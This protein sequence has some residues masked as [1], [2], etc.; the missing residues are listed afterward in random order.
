MRVAVGMITLG[1]HFDAGRYHATKWATSA[2]EGQIDWPPSPW[3]ILRAIVSSWKTYHD[4]IPDDAMSPIIRAMCSEA[5]KFRLPPASQSHTRHYVPVI[6]HDGK[7]LTKTEKMIDAFLVIGGNETLYVMWS[8]EI[9]EE[10]KSTLQA[11]V[12]DL[13][14]LGRAESWCHAFVADERIEPNCA[15]LGSDDVVGDAQ[16]TDIMCPRHDATLENICVRVQDLHYK[17][18]PYPPK[19]TMINYVIQPHAKIGTRAATSYLAQDA[20][21]VR[22]RI[23]GSVKPKITEVVAVGDAFKRVAMAKYRRQNP[24]VEMSGTLSGRN[25]D[26]SVKKDNHSHAFFLP[27]AEDNSRVLDHITVVSKEPFTDKEIQALGA[28]KKVWRDKMFC[29]VYM[30]KGKTDSW[31]AAILG[32]ARKWE[33]ITPYVPNRHPK[34][35]GTGSDRKKVDSPEDQIVRELKNRGFPSIKNVSVRGSDARVSGFLPVEF[36]RWR[37]SGLAA[38]GA[39]SATIEFNESVR[40][41]LSL[42]HSSHFGLGMFAP[43]TGTATEGESA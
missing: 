14:Y 20:T 32:S 35:R 4:D 7:S 37:K 21:V 8:C 40:G 11:I 38:F 24:D 39:C 27:T 1:F 23:T 22:F 16:I 33:S 2:S 17:N 29:T 30:D 36:R 26:R 43:A 31:D 6:S 28:V 41:P 25:P 10:Q 12:Q 19:T 18:T 42:G 13:R 9:S 15:P 3:R 5:P 34:F